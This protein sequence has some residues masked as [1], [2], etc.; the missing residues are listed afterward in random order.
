MSHKPDYKRLPYEKHRKHRYYREDHPQ[1][2]A[3]KRR[4]R[5]A[6]RTQ[7]KNR[8]DTAFGKINW[9]AYSHRQ[10]YDMIMT[11]DPAGM[12]SA[13]HQWA[14]LALNVDSATSAV[15]KTVQK[16]LLS[17]R[18]GAAGGAAQSATKLTSW[19][20]GASGTM[21]QVGDDLDHYTTAV[22]TARNKMPEPVFYSAENQ[23]RDGYDVKA[24]SGPS[25]AVMVDQLLDDHL[26]AK[27]KASSA[28]TEAVR[29]MEHYETTSKGVHDKLPH[30]TDAPVATR[31][32]P[33]GDAGSGPGG[34]PDPD[35][36]TTASAGFGAPGGMPGASGPGAGAGMPG[37]IGA[38]IGGAGSAGGAL[39]GGTSSG[40]PG[41]GA[42]V[43]G[44]AFGGPSGT[45]A[46]GAAQSAAGARSGMGGG[47]FPP[48]G[49]GRGG[50][51]DG[52]HQNRYTKGGSFDFLEDMPSAYPPVLGE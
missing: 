22:T 48:M 25:G 46:A 3:H 42:A 11:A 21:R 51:G 37:S 36:T 39:G 23:F 12:G 38:G 8:K 18:G 30:F 52:E 31:S 20:A 49:G 29:V 32:D 45:A 14:E 50:E 41:S 6:R 16:L 17:W 40:G 15:H 4:V 43:P 10:L 27:K 24:A 7:T 2:A 19:G 35:G 26:P 28:K 5:R 34:G 47:F 1:T 9:D 13:A 44:S 33:G